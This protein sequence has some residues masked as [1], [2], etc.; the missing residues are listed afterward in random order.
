VLLS[1][2]F[3]NSGLCDKRSWYSKLFPWDWGPTHDLWFILNTTEVYP[4]SLWHGLTWLPP[5]EFTRLCL[6]MISWLCLM[7]PLLSSEDSTRYR[8]VIGAL[9]YLSLTR[10]DISFAANRV[11]QFMTKP[12][13][14]HWS[15]VKRILRYLNHT[16]QLGLCF[17]KS[18][19]LFLS[20]FSYVDW[21]GDT[22]DHCSLGGYAISLAAT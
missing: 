13:S 11:C 10:P 19:S 12:T 18:A 4:W 21:A 3:I 17:V 8:G 5:M 20:A 1:G 6:L 16:I 14:S 7:A 22:D 2:Y 9:Q 15:A